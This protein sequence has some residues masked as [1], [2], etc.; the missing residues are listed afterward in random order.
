MCN[1]LED[2]KMWIFCFR[3]WSRVTGWPIWTTRH[4]SMSEMKAIIIF[5]VEHQKLID[6]KLFTAVMI[7]LRSPQLFLVLE[8]QQFWLILGLFLIALDKFEGMYKWKGLAAWI[9]SI[10]SK[11]TIWGFMVTQN[12]VKPPPSTNDA[13][14]NV[15]DLQKHHIFARVYWEGWK[16]LKGFVIPTCYTQTS[17]FYLKSTFL[18]FWYR[19]KQVN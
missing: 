3:T 9:K 16:S 13:V 11:S 7:S 10:S 17:L 2:R 19:F 18:M 8:V 12:I 1:V 5:I 6:D 15:V 14:L 4:K